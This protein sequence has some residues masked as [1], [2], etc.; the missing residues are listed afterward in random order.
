MTGSNM[1][2]ASVAGAMRRR[3]QILC[4]STALMMC[5]MP[6]LA[7]AQ[8][9]GTSNASEQA[10]DSA[11]SQGAI[12]VTGSRVARSGFDNPTPTTIINA[13]QI[14]NTGLN[15]ISDVL[16]QSPQI[17]VGLGSSN[18]TFQRDIGA[19]FI[20]LRGLGENRTLVL[21]DGRRRVSGSR[22]GSQVDVSAIPTSMIKSVEVI[23]GGASAVYGADAVSGVVNIILKDDIEGFE[24]SGRVGLSDRG[25]GATY[26][27]STSGGGQ[28]ADGRGSA[29]FGLNYSKSET[30]KYTDRS[31]TYGEG[32]LRFVN[33]PDNTGPDDGI[34]DRIVITNPRTITSSY[35]PSFVIGGQRYYY[36]NGLATQ[37]GVDC[38][39]S[40]CSGGD[41]GYDNRERNLRNP[42]ESFSAIAGLEYELSDNITAFTD[43]EFSF[44]NSETNGQGFFDSS[45][46]LQRDNPTLPDEVTALM[47]ANGL[48]TL[49]VGY[50]GEYIFGNREHGNSRYI[51]TVTGG[52]RG[53]VANFD[54]EAFAQYG[55]RDQRYKRGNSRIE[56]R[57]YEAVDAVIDPDTGEMVCRSEA[58]QAAGCRPISVFDGM[59]SDEDKAYFEATFMREVTNEQ[60]L[61]G[62][63]ATGSL[64]DLP[65]G[66]LGVAIGAEYRR[67]SLSTLDDPLGARGLLYRTDNGGE[68]VDASAEV[69]EAF[70]EFV[71][72]VLKDSFLGKSLQVEGAARYSHYDTI[73]STLAWKLGGEWAPI[74]DLRFRVTRSRSVRAPTIV[75]LF[76]PETI[77]ALNITA[78]PCDAAE[79]NQNPNRLAN[80]RALGI[81]VGWV[82]PAASLA[83]TTRLGGNPDL[84]EETSNSWTA[85][86]VT[87]PVDG[88][89]LS[90]DWWSI[91]IDDAIQTISGNSI[92]E[93]CVDSESLDNPF[94]ALVTRGN[95][96]GLSDPYVISSIDLRQVNVGSLTARGVD[97]AASYYTYLD[98]ISSS[99]PGRLTV[100]ATLT[101]LDKLEELVDATDETTLLIKDGEYENPTW[102]ANLNLGYA[103]GNLRANWKV[104]YIGPSSLDV[105]KSAEYYG[106]VTVD[107]RFYHDLSINYELDD[108]SSL[109]LGVNNLFDEHPPRT[110]S[111]YTGAYGS[112]LFD[113]VGRFFYL[114]ATKKF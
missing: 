70:A 24:V 56:S 29:R 3:K 65:A 7:Y 71:V 104:R 91:K 108:G 8:D 106:G 105:E 22:D 92:V 62:I 27:I 11:D 95:F 52:L 89:T 6:S 5:L 53:K 74:D 51:Y 49:K 85:G 57:F 59:V 25:D 103:V 23:T 86:V 35:E 98:K 13:E 77:G 48:S 60:F 66:P 87:T 64:I 88:L 39:G 67:D 54:W 9:S 36:D 76:A 113:S 20:N 37:S 93:K 84:Q 82:D 96:V 73:G 69:V 94:C 14:A 46:T 4:G 10:Q 102:R 12:V 31:Y 80:C 33:N 79:I 112:S 47:D 101:Y 58:A 28:F 61:A 114:G 44:A 18:D 40:Y 1:G 45:L 63:Q 17:A 41:Y 97:F 19:S 75:E 21:V 78:D 99:L 72:P 30:L 68:S 83:L 50:E 111:T 110:P 34:P 81:P 90:A 38:Y 109:Q 32:A 15:D 100:T 107:E 55:R 16:M 26:R 42:R 43:F 2:Q